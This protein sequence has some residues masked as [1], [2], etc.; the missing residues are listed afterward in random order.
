MSTWCDD[1]RL[2]PDSARKLDSSR[3]YALLYPGYEAIGGYAKFSVREGQCTSEVGG[4]S[5]DQQLKIESPE[6]KCRQAEEA[7][8]YERPINRATP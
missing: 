2:I 4:H 7:S 6:T 5:A 8:S 1:A 3:A